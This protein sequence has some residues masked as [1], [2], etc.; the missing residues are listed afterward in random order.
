MAPA[1]ELARRGRGRRRRDRAPLLT[2]RTHRRPI[3]SIEVGLPGG[4]SGLRTA[5]WLR[6][7]IAINSV[8]GWRLVAMTKLG[9]QVLASG[10]ELLFTDHELSFLGDYARE[11]QPPVLIGWG[12][13]SGWSPIWGLKRPQA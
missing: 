1:D 7:S 8:I 12:Q 13:R 11:F 2:T 3:P 5:D 4:A 6:Q 9:Q 10:A